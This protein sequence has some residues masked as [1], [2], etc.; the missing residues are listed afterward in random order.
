M[1]SQI[2][3]NEEMKGIIEIVN[4]ILDGDRSGVGSH[5]SLSVIPL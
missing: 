4:P 3:S 2:T 5:P 1:N